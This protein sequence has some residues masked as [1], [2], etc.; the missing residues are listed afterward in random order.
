M[1]K[2]QK[3]PINRL[4]I[5]SSFLLLIVG[6]SL[7]VPLFLVDNINELFVLGQSSGRGGKFNTILTSILGLVFVIYGFRQLITKK[8]N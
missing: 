4:A 5:F 7:L 8:K 2:Q 1:T 3:K 6:L